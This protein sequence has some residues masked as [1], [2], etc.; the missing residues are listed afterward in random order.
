MSS[1]TALYVKDA[2]RKKCYKSNSCLYDFSPEKSNARLHL[3]YKWEEGNIG[4]D[5]DLEK[6]SLRQD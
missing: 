2:L 6:I 3:R 5:K 4:V 1:S